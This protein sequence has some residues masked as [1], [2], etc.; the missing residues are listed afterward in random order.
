MSAHAARVGLRG[1][2]VNIKKRFI[3]AASVLTGLCSAG[4][5]VGAEGDGPPT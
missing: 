1:I 5:A 2:Y 4:Y 3:V